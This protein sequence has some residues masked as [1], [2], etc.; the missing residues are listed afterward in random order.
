MLNTYLSSGI[1]DSSEKSR[2]C[3]KEHQTSQHGQ[4]AAQHANGSVSHQVFQRF[5]EEEGF[6]VIHGR[7]MDIFDV[8]ESVVP[9]SAHPMYHSMVVRKE[10]RHKTEL[11]PFQLAHVP[12]TL[13]ASILLNG[14]SHVPAKLSVHL[15]PRQAI[16]GEG[17]GGKPAS[18]CRVQRQTS[19]PSIE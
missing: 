8:L 9:A 12:S 5:T 15:I 1:S 13:R 16:P 7:T 4:Q 3:G 10:T 14:H 18:H 6:H 19:P 11:L 17:V 2:Y